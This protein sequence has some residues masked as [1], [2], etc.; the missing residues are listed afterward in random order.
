[1]RL[2]LF[3]SYP[4]SG[5]PPGHGMAWHAR[6]QNCYLYHSGIE[7]LV[8]HLG[9]RAVIRSS[10]SGAWRVHGGA[11]GGDAA[12]CRVDR[13]GGDGVGGGVIAG[14]R[15]S[16][17]RGLGNVGGGG[18]IWVHHCALHQCCACL[19][20]GCTHCSHHALLIVAQKGQ[21]HRGID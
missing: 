18:A 12:C 16:I 9:L 11:G 5:M 15:A 10:C 21:Y 4:G 7:G 14:V 2:Y 17:L 6:M 13:G 20:H 19:G 1:M 3:H 8:L